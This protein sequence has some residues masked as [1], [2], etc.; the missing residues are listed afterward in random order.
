MSDM[1]HKQLETMLAY[2]RAHPDVDWDHHLVY[3]RRN[4]DGSW[5]AVNHRPKTVYDYEMDKATCWCCMKEVCTCDPP[6]PH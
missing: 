3:L 4:S 6:H 5:E 2:Q 1:A